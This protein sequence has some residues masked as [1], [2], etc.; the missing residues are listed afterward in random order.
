MELT[1]REFSIEKDNPV[2]QRFLNHNTELLNAV[3]ADRRTAQV[4]FSSLGWGRWFVPGLMLTTSVLQDVYDSAV[5]YFGENS[6]TTPPSMFF[7]VFVRFIKA[8]K[9]S[10]GRT[11]TK[12]LQRR[13]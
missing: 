4:A 12:M 2:L 7:P 5:E 1:R 11:D 10:K 13:R 3:A 8:Y 6:K 9:V